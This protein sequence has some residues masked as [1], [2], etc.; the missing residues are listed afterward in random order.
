MKRKSLKLYS[1]AN[2]FNI[3]E[4][5]L[6]AIALTIGGVL[7]LCNKY[8]WQGNSVFEV[9]DGVR[10]CVENHDLVFP[11]TLFTYIGLGVLVVSIIAK[12]AMGK[13]KRWPK[14]N[15][16][17][18]I[19][20]II[21]GLLSLNLFMVVAGI[22]T[23][24]AAKSDDGSTQDKEHIGLKAQKA[25]TNTFS[26][27]GL[28]VICIVWI[29]P[30]VFIVLQ[31]FR[32]E[33]NSMVGYLFPKQWGFDNYA[34]LFSADSDFLLWYFNTF[35]IALACAV[36]QTVM[37]LMM[38][39]TL[40]R[41]RFKLRK[42]LMNIMLILGMFPGFL[43]MIVL[44]NVLKNIGLTGSNAIG[45]LIL[46][47]CASSGMGY[48]VSKGFFDTVPKSLDEAARIDGATRMQI[49]F[50]VILPLAKPI[51]IYT[52]LTAFMAPWGDFIFAQFIA[53]GKPLG[54]NVAV[55][56]NSWLSQEMLNG[57]YTRF[58]AG[59]VIVAIPV[60]VIFMFL[61]RYYVEG[62]TGG[63]VKG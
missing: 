37:Q 47:Y 63:A 43:S 14:P 28:A 20:A 42:P 58:C 52:I 41:F 30:F 26:Y 56:L 62:V 54:Y 31:S 3:I 29:I 34:Y 11:A 24:V 13:A 18:N 9:Q 27:F 53:F 8:Y 33:T 40:S 36:I 15:K 45:G 35:I 12:I 22:L 25:I 48:Y 19:L 49:F 1:I 38:A 21:F 32:T 44:Y 51:V 50:K 10:V 17:A 46:V 16:V 23:L 57:Y 60:I 61:Q 59:G 5:F 2:V 4:I 55:G 6:S 39:Y 7:F